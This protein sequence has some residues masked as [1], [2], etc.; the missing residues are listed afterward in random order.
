MPH[1]TPPR[2]QQTPAPRLRQRYG[3]VIGSILALSLCTAGLVYWQ[4]LKPDGL[5]YHLGTFETALQAARQADRLCFVKFESAYCYPCQQLDQRLKHTP[6]FAH[7]VESA[8]L[9]YRIDP[10]DHYSGG[11]DLARR[12]HIDELPTLL[13]TDPDGH[14]ITR[15][16]GLA[17][18][19]DLRDLLAK[20]A[21][22]RLPPVRG[23][24]AS[25][26]Y[27]LPAEA[28]T[29]APDTRHFGLATSQY[30]TFLEARRAALHRE[31]QWN[32]AVWIQPRR[33]GKGFH[34]VLGAFDHRREARLTQRFLRVWEKADTKVVP[35]RASPLPM[36]K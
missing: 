8:Y 6:G 36:G 32:Q 24:V 12:Y 25:A 13:I 15:L 18:A 28:D 7:A 23:E 1:A 16:E 5:T 26:R 19:E 10:F 21:A 29:L 34:L 33:W 22:L 30:D 27:A 31:R 9:L 20:H 4:Q 11:H 35:L 17:D 2:S 14:E 3:Y